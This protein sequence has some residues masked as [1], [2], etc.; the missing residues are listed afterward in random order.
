[1][2]MEAWNSKLKLDIFSFIILYFLHILQT[3]LSFFL[4]LLACSLAL[5]LFSFFFFFIFRSWSFHTI[6]SYELSLSRAFFPSWPNRI[7]NLS[8]SRPCKRKCTG[9]QFFQDENWWKN[10]CHSKMPFPVVNVRETKKKVTKFLF[11]TRQLFSHRHAGKYNYVQCTRLGR[12]IAEKKK[13]LKKLK[14][15]TKKLYTRSEK[16]NCR[17]RTNKN[18]ESRTRSTRVRLAK[19]CVSARTILLASLIDP[20]CGCRKTWR[21]NNIEPT[22]RKTNINLV[23]EILFIFVSAQS[24]TS[25]EIT[26]NLFLSLQSVTFISSPNL[27]HRQPKTLVVA[28][29][30]IKSY[31]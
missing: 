6:Q 13:K 29:S 5:S 18:F 1:M 4:A 3:F 21:K 25:V 12:R 17:W 26:E 8:I 11:Q 7:F 10:D 30:I 15:K 19:S 20:A 22:K 14:K 31:S 16:K 23:D 2:D 27:D 9:I 28:E 24:W